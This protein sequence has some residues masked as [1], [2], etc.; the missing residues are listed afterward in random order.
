[1]AL[2]VG[3][4]R[5]ACEDALELIEVEY[6]PLPAPLADIDAA[7][8]GDVPPIHPEAPGNLCLEAEAGR[9]F[10]GGDIVAALGSIFGR[11]T[12]VPLEPR[13]LIADY[14]PGRG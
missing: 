12:G 8:A 13:G 4:S 3:E 6:S 2:V 1:M 10:E 9:G 11:H 14:A 7:L 5:A